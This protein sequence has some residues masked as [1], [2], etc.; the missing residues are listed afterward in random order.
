M[1]LHPPSPQAFGEVTIG[2][3]QAAVAN[4]RTVTRPLAQSV[5]RIHGKEKPGAILLVP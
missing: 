3:S 1:D 2:L 5:E 4:C